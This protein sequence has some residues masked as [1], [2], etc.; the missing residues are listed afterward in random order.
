MAG[1]S[2]ETVTTTEPWEAQRDYLKK[3]FGQA[4]KLY[5]RG[6]PAYYKGS[7]LAGFDPAQTASQQG[8]LNYALGPRA[9]AQQ[10]AA[11]NALLRG[12]SGQIDPNAYNPMV[13]ALSQ[14]VQ[15]EIQQNILPGIRESLVRYQPGGSSRGDLEQNK[16]IAGAVTSGM[17]KPLAEMYTNAYNQA[18]NRAVQTGSQYPSIMSAPLGMLG[19]AGQVG[20]VRQ[21]QTQ[22]D[23][24]R[25]M[26]RH[27]YDAMSDYNALNQ[28]MNTIA[29]NYGG[30]VTQT[31]PGK[32]L[33]GVLGS[34][35]PVLLGG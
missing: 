3:G 4:E 26:A 10:A 5:N 32:G 17:T 25:A 1:G 33:G 18:Q 2:K 27:D 6:L 16:A 14:G 30:T 24:D 31:V 19:A 12:F 7:T 23:I 11:E 20:D 28:Y 8:I 22:Q 29:G 15:S 21:A 34:I 13:N 9:G 35:L